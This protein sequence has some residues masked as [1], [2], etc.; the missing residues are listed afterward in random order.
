MADLRLDFQPNGGSVTPNRRSWEL[1]SGWR[2]ANN[3]RLNGRLQK[4]T[5]S[6]EEATSTTTETVGLDLTGP[7][8]F[9]PATGASLNIGGFI[10]DQASRDKVTHNLTR[11]FTMDL[12]FPLP[13]G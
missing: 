7:V 13:D 11:S 3:L 8:P 4:F 6:L 9:A 2:F 12:G 10:Q 5:D 1:R